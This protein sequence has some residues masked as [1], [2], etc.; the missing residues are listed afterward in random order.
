MKTKRLLGAAIL[1][2][3]ALITVLPTVP[4]AS[5]RENG[6]STSA[7]D[8]HDLWRELWVD[9]ITWTRMVIMGTFDSLPGNDAYKARLIQNY[10]DM[11]DALEP[12][13]GDEAE[14]W[15][16]LIEEHLLI[17]VE[18]LDAAK[19]GNTA[20]LDDAKA[21]WYDNGHE[22]AN[23]M[24]EMNP[25]FWPASMGDPMWIEHLDA[26]FDEAVAH[27][28]NDFAGDVAAYDLVVDLAI[29]M[30][31]FMSNGVVQQF[32]GSF[33]GKKCVLGR[34]GKSQDDEDDDDD[35]D[36]GEDDDDD[37]G[38]HDDDDDEESG[39]TSTLSFRMQSNLVPGARRFQFELGQSNPVSLVIFDLSGREVA[40]VFEGTL[41]KGPH[42]LS[43]DGRVAGGSEP[44]KGIYFARL[45]AGT[46][47]GT[48][49]LVEQ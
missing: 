39:Q 38:N 16:E 49:K 44:A 14:E 29:E 7:L 21:R 12:Y 8:Y 20:A 13:Y 37:N 3:L 30:A 28:T 22:I 10:F 6:S 48:I 19:A 24:A 40:R 27:L 31:D 18:I 36:D 17:A 25:D 34:P 11:E 35:G 43:W 41:E 9:H 15:G 46:Q 47:K 1:V 5:A 42:A 45:T 32:P 26:T 2:A 33:S 4:H 23:F